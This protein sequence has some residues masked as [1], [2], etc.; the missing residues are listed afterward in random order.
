MRGEET[1]EPNGEGRERVGDM[2]NRGESMLS[3]KKL[4][5][6]MEEG[7]DGGEREESGDEQAGVAGDEGLEEGTAEMPL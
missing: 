3:P 2:G 5:E 6:D 7:E 4:N 1:G